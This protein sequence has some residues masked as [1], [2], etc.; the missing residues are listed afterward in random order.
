M[1]LMLALACLL[2]AAVASAETVRFATFNV[3]LNRA[4]PGLLLRDIEKGE[5]AQIDAV[6]RIITEVAP[7]VLLLNEFDHDLDGVALAAFRKRLK[8]AG[9]DY[10]HAFAGPSNTGQPSGFDLNG[11]GKLNEAAD[12][13]GFGNFPGQY[14]MALLSKYPIMEAD[15]RSFQFFPWSNL[16]GALLPIR[17]D[18]SPFPS[19]DVWPE[20]R[21]SSKSHWDVPVVIGDAVVHVLASHPTPPVFDGPEDMNGRRNHDEIVFWAAYLDG[22]SPL[23]D[24]NR[25]EPFAGGH[26]VVMGDLNADP[27]TATA[28]MTG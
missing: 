6:I 19:A 1:R 23:D 3:S 24:Q 12:A 22:F 15:I 28:S 13:F 20:I 7:D 21:L 8:A 26:A 14:G 5:D 25:T 2:W 17:A 27:G 10:P 16:P 18:G 4:G 11:N 9:Q